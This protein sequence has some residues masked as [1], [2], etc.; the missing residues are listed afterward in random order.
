MLF[1]SIV[2]Y[3]LALL[4]FSLA[5]TW[6]GV[7]GNIYLVGALICGVAFLC[8]GVSTARGKTRADAR[9]LLRAS[10]LYLPLIY[11]LMMFD[12]VAR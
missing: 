3:T 6:L 11:A 4:P 12:K 2:L 9:R 1:R 7:T 8:V 5:P 10:V